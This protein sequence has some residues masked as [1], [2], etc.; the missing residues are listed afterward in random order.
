MNT[1][2]IQRDVLKA[3]EQRSGRSLTVLQTPNLPTLATI[4]F[5]D[6]NRP[7]HIIEVNAD[8]AWAIDYL[9][10]FQCGMLIR[11]LEAAEEEPVDIGPSARGLE[12]V[13]EALRR[14]PALTAVPA[15]ALQPVA[16]QLLAGIITHLRSVPVGFSVDASIFEDFEPLRELQEGVVNI[17]LKQNEKSLSAA[18]SQLIP[19]RIGDATNAISAAFAAFWSVRWHKPTVLVPYKTD[20]HDVKGVRLVDIWTDSD[21]GGDS[22]VIDAWAEELGVAGWY[23]WLPRSRDARSDG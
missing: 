20:G 2:E 9:V 23:Q 18:D 21:R 13:S 19:K 7:G 14:N 11:R 16:E 12:E 6:H 5:A 1:R 22:A 4:H 8:Y 10:V 3:C 15:H 17:Q